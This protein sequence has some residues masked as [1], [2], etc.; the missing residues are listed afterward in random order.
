MGSK[1][2]NSRKLVIIREFDDRTEA[3]MAREYLVS[4][5]IHAELRDAETD[6]GESPEWIELRVHPDDSSEAIKLLEEGDDEN[7]EDDEDYDD[8]E[9]YDDDYDYDDEPEEEYDERY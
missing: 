7:F 9:E 4:C 5:D 6:N 2:K 1:G 3:E 8:D